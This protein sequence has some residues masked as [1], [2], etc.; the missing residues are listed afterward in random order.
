MPASTSL[1]LKCFV[2]IQKVYYKKIENISCFVN[3][4]YH[5]EKFATWRGFNEIIKVLQI[6]VLSFYIFYLSLS[7]YKLQLDYFIIIIYYS[8]N[9]LFRCFILPNRPYALATL[10]AWKCQN[11]EFF[12]VRIFQ[13]LEIYGVNLRIQSKYWKIRT[14]K[15]SLFGP[16]SRSDY[17]SCYWYMKHH[18]TCISLLQLQISC[19]PNS[20]TIF[21]HNFYT[22]NIKYFEC[23]PYYN[24]Y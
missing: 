20:K 12:L 10:T 9:W 24:V 19:L 3:W 1:R 23:K 5:G 22:N 16:F 2:K 14:R 15:N 11:T 21:I 7:N 4:N 13:Y 8:K 6:F 18:Y 17:E